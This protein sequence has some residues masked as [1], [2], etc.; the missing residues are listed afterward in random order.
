MASRIQF[1]RVSRLFSALAIVLILSFIAILPAYAKNNAGG[2]SC[3]CQNGYQFNQGQTQCISIPKAET[4]TIAPIIKKIS[5]VKEDIAN[6]A[7]PDS[8]NLDRVIVTNTEKVK[9]KSFWA[10]IKNWLGF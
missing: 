7:K 3:G 2:L 1:L 5:E 6:I 4:K 9:P 10:K 8:V